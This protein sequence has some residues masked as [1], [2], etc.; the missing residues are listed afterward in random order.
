MNT[1]TKILA[2][3]L[4]LASLLAAPRA[5]APPPPVTL[6]LAQPAS[7]SPGTPAGWGFTLT[8]GTTAYLVVTG[9]TASPGVTAVGTFTDFAAQFQFVVVPPSSFV[10]QSFNN[11]SQTGAGSLLSSLAGASA[12][13]T[14][15]MTYDLY[16][17][18]PTLGGFDPIASGV[19]WGSRVSAAAIF[20]TTPVTLEWF[21]VR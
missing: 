11:G 15:T 9:V 16:S 19:S 2:I 4:V 8:N 18:D 13:G 7:A 10:T 1:H 17:T 5:F 6:V 3:G 14:I 12:S 21:D 20:G